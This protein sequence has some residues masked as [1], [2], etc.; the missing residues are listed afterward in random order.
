MMDLVQWLNALPMSSAVRRISW[1]IPL[2]QTIHIL[3]TGVI[4]SSAIMIALRIWGV[5]RSQT[6][7][8]S[9]LRF[10]PWIWS[11]MV[12]LTFTGVVLIMG[13]SRRALLDPTF[14]VKI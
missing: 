10:E 12:L 8:E 2:M 9:A 14:Q 7:V 5:A 13:A 6:F 1:V 11:A 4:L 3:A